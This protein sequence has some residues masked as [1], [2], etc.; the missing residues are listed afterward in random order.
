MEALKLG[1]GGIGYIASLFACSRT[2][3]CE[4]IKELHVLPEDASY[5]PRIRRPGAGRKPYEQTYPGI[6]EAFLEV[7]QN[8]T[9]GDPMQEGVLWTNLTPKEIAHKLEEQHGF[10]VSKTVVRQLL[11]KHHFSRRKAQKNRP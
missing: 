9:A 4:G 1:H 3:V 11:K 8:H 6:D 2:T 5:D 7:V 10:K